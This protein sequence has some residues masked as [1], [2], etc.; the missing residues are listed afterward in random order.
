VI[1][2]TELQDPIVKNWSKVS[3]EG[4]DDH[5]VLMIHMLPKYGVSQL[6]QPSSLQRFSHAAI[7][8]D[9]C[10]CACPQARH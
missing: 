6:H 5:D 4:L 3:K 1:V 2:L 8:S 7:D 10:R 9:C